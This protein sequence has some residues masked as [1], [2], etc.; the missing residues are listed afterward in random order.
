MPLLAYRAGRVREGESNI[1]FMRAFPE[2]R[3]GAVLAE[4]DKLM[5]RGHRLVVFV[6]DTQVMRREK[7]DE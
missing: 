5:K 2:S 6:S 1:L 4:V 3:L 7:F